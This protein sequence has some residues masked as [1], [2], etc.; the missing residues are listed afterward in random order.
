MSNN[1][2][3][4]PQTLRKKGFLQGSSRVCW[5]I[6]GSSLIEKHFII[7]FYNKMRVPLRDITEEPL[8]VYDMTRHNI[9][10]VHPGSCIVDC[11]SFGPHGL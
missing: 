4:V 8:R 10:N 5:I 9:T 6:K 11:K 7:G 1:L 2:E 3:F